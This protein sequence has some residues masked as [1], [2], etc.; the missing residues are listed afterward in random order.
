MRKRC[1]LAID[2]THPVNISFEADRPIDRVPPFFVGFP[3]RKEVMRMDYHSRS[4]GLTLALEV[5]S[6]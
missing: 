5:T 3:A 6:S 1:Q 2:I 4:Y